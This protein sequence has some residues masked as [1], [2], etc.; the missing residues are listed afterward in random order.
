MALFDQKQIQQDLQI[1]EENIKLLE[2]R[3]TDYF[4]GVIALEPKAL[5]V[6]TDALVRKWWGKPL[7][8]TQIRFKLQNIV[9]RYNAY[10]EKWNRQLRL[11]ARAEKEEEF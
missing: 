2:K 11:K 5:R 10:K 3:Y 9:Q 1:I 7:T 4:D 8:S 6:Q